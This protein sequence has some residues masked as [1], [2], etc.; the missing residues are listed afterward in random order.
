MRPAESEYILDFYGR[1]CKCQEVLQSCK[2]WFTYIR[3]PN[4]A[5]AKMDHLLLT[6]TFLLLLWL[7]KHQ[8]RIIPH[9]NSSVLYPQLIV[10]KLYSY[11]RI[12]SKRVWLRGELRMT[13]QKYQFMQHKRQL[14]TRLGYFCIS[15]RPLFTRYQIT[16][17]SG[18]FLYW[19]RVVFILL[20]LNP[21]RS[22]TTIRYN[23]APH[24]QVEQKWIWYNPFLFFYL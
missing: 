16:C 20:C 9:R 3:Q 23:S 6:I 21:I 24:Q 17:L 12:R 11:R 13:P 2:G 5:E 18:Y 19:I 14:I 1:F 8:W 4:L 22:A 15:L 10:V 7:E